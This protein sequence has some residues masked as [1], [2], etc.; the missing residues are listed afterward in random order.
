LV[1]KE[2]V[3]CDSWRKAAWAEDLNVARELANKHRTWV[4]IV[5]VTD[6]VQ[7]RLANRDLAEFWLR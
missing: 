7:E 2:V 4:A 1:I 6:C 5:A 3:R